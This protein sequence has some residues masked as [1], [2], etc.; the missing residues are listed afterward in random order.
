[1]LKTAL[2]A[3]TALALAGAASAAEAPGLSV[4]I[5]NADLA[6][7]RDARQLDIASGRQKLEFKVTAES[8]PHGTKGGDPI[9]RLPL[10]AGAETTLR[11]TVSF[12]R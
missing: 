6:L 8:A 9:W 11:Y 5:Y 12:N 7:V 4:T 10:A 2:F 1:L 3:A